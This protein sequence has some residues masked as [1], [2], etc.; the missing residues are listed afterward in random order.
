MEVPEYKSDL[1]KLTSGGASMETQVYLALNIIDL[2]FNIIDIFAP[3]MGSCF[4][5]LPFIP[6]THRTPLGSLQGS[7]TP[8]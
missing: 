6:Q 5:H 7:N 8:P 1:C 4:A 2:G 3:D